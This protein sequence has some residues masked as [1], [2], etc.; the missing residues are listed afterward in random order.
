MK[1][2]D[3][4]KG[5]MSRATHAE[6]RSNRNAWAAEMAAEGHSFHQIG[7]ALGISTRSAY[8][9]SIKGGRAKKVPKRS[10]K[11][12]MENASIVIGR[13]GPHFWKLPEALQD[14]MIDEA[15]R[16]KIS[17]SEALVAFYAKAHQ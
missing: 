7:K 5:R 12:I 8:N 17:I 9:A 1:A 6:I 15:S 13:V 4:I 3:Y 14:K 16:R 2:P 10:P 11:R